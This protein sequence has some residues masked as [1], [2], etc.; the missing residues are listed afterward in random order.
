MEGASPSW[1]VGVH[2]TALDPAKLLAEVGDTTAGAVVLFLGTAR[3]TTTE[4]RHHPLEY[5]AYPEWS[6]KSWRDR[7]RGR[8]KWPLVRLGSSI[9]RR[10]FC[11]Y[12]SWCGVSTRRTLM[13]RRCGVTFVIDELKKRA[14]DLEEGHWEGGGERSKGKELSLPRLDKIGPSILRAY[15]RRDTS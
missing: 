10:G 13:A 6:S 9:D 8:D 11:R 4:R 12:P 15:D 7:R 14:A 1:R 2:E 3:D 5:A